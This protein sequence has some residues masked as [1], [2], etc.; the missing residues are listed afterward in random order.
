MNS[1]SPVRSGRFASAMRP[2]VRTVALGIAMLVG[3]L[4]LVTSAST[5]AS[6]KVVTGAI[7]RVTVTP[8][9]SSVYDP[10]S[11]N[12]A[13]C[14]PNGTAAGDTFALAL[15]PQLVPLTTGFA[16]KDAAGDLVATATVTG[17]VATFTMTSFASTHNDV[18]GTA[19][20]N[21]SIDTTK[22]TVNQP[23]TL[24]FSTGS[25]VFHP[26]ITPTQGT[27]PNRANPQKYGNWADRADQ[28]KN[29][30][31][32]ALT[33]YID[34]PLAPKPGGYRT[35]VF[36]D[37]AT[38]GQEFDCAKVQVQVGTFNA[39]GNFVEA[40]AYKGT[41]S[42]TCSAA[43]LTVTTGAVPAG[44]ALHV[45]IP[46]TITDSS[47]SAYSDSAHVKLDGAPTATVVAQNV[48][49]YDAGG[50]GAG[51]AP[52]PVPATTPTTSTPTPTP[53]PTPSAA[54]TTPVPTTPVSS[55]TT[56]APT[57]ATPPLAMTGFEANGYIWTGAA[58]LT[59]GGG[60]MLIAAYWQRGRRAR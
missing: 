8:A 23:N 4:L 33:W 17:G 37:S 21:E 36:T 43:S 16:L 55:P 27:G 20:F 9:A 3:A 1:T 7:S 45:V 29:S 40:G 31:T 59:I 57:R 51:V 5:A 60:L 19:Y 32:D 41:V 14:V 2:P 13:W 54:T 53:T 52:T 6:A 42:K 46:T 34:S 15:P 28:G 48:V 10:I 25:T 38:A 12:L 47:L 56:S 24:T 44:Q 30:P 39:V 58:F 35:A 18:C 26:V 11:V 22:V 50:D 49:R